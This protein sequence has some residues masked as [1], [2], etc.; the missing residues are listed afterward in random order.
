MSN[1]SH[2]SLVYKYSGEG[3]RFIQIDSDNYKIVLFVEPN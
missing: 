2:S 3:S 1:N